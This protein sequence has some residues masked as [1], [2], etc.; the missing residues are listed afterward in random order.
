MLCFSSLSRARA[1]K[2]CR[3]RLA[4]RRSI[5]RQEITSLLKGRSS[6][7]LNAALSMYWYMYRNTVSFRLFS[8]FRLPHLVQTSS[9]AVTQKINSLACISASLIVY[10]PPDLVPRHFRSSLS[11][12]L[13][14]TRIHVVV[15]MHIMVPI[16]QRLSWN[17]I[18]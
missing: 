10:Y 11:M 7:V 13:P 2:V 16:T 8:S 15:R 3:S 4:S 1:G 17:T 6:N 12:S 18:V 9:W 5:R 14:T